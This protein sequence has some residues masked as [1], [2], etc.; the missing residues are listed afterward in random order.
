ME[1]KH[2]TQK[3]FYSVII[4]TEEDKAECQVELVT[5]DYLDDNRSTLINEF[6][7]VRLPNAVD[8]RLVVDQI[9]SDLK[10]NHE[11]E[12]QFSGYDGLSVEIQRVQ[13]EPEFKHS[14]C[15]ICKSGGNSVYECI[16]YNDV[17]E[18]AAGEYVD[19]NICPD[20]LIEHQG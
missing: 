3:Q 17:H 20:C 1:Y 7:N 15:D 19:L 5:G 2:V 9:L 18:I 10:S 13:S 12:G 6:E 16:G 11:L 4:E 8:Y 14:G